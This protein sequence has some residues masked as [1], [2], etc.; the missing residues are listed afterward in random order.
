MKEMVN[1]LLAAGAAIGAL[2]AAQTALAQDAPSVAEAASHGDDEI[3][4]TAQK[5]ETNLQDTPLAISAIGGSTME[6]RGIDDVANLQS[7]VPNLRVGQE[8]DG[9]KI[10]LRGIGIQGTSSITDNGV[11]FYQDNFYISRPAGGSAVFYDV[12]RV[13]VLRGPQGTLYGRNATGGVINVISNEPSMRDFS[14]EV[15]ASYGSRNLWEV[16]GWV[17]AP[18]GDVAAVRLSAVYTE[19]DGYLKNLGGRDLYGTDGDLTVRGQVKVGDVDSVELLLYGLYS[20][21][22]GTGSANQ[23][24]QRNIGGPPPVQALLRTLPALNLN[25]RVTNINAPTYLTVETKLAFARLR[26]DFGGVEAYLQVGRMWQDSHNQQDFD[27]SPVD[28]SIFNKDQDNKSTSVEARLASTGDGPFSWIVGGYYFDESTYILRR[29]RLK[30]LT[31][32]G[33]I[34]L[35]DFILDEYGNSETIAGF[36]SA[37]YA[38]GD[39]LRLTGGIRYTEDRKDGRKI[40]RG[41][42]GQPFP[43]DL[44]NAMFPADVKFDKVTWKAGIEYDVAPDVLAYASVS[45]G[46]KAGGFNLSSDGRPYD[47]ETITAY[48]FGIKSDLFDRVARINLDAF[49]YDY[50]NLQLTTLGVAADGVTPGQFTTNAAASTIWGIELDTRWRLS[51]RFTFTAGYSYI[52]AQFDEYLNRDPLAGPGPVL[53]L[54]GNQLPFVSRHTV[55][56]G[57]NYEVELG[58]G[59]LTFAA[60]SNF[61]S[62]FFL[63]EFNNYAIDRVPSNTKTD[64]TI[65]YRLSDPGLSITGYVTNIEDNV[66]RNNIYLTPGFIGVSPTTAYSKPR[67][68][69]VRVDYSF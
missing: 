15:G 23:F 43:P 7:Y 32:G 11:A 66:E 13:E 14:G 1:R 60:N 58:A 26:K 48:E 21:L 57:I 59:T 25:P 46:Y 41:N 33:V 44:P 27:G 36:A 54:S 63:R 38:L 34:S 19:E 50:T 40:T 12:N 62:A 16:R 22:K 4:V 56:L 3:V 8:Q 2:A 47:P 65:T 18:L 29:V 6:E 64:L 39:A 61:H 45:N 20:K 35:P 28:V 52:D 51:D 9:V 10:T 67:T 17:N 42:F 49:Y 68:V 24:L 55:N 37:T 30:G 31:P 5:R 69:G 53:D